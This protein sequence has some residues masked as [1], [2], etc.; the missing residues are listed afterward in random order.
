MPPSG[1]MRALTM[2]GFGG[3]ERLE[4]RE[5]P[6]PGPPGP[7]EVLVRIRAGALNRI[8]LFVLRG[9]PKARYAFPH[10]V[11]SDGAGLVEAVGEGVTDVHPG[12]RVMIN[13][14]LSCRRCPACLAGEQPYCREFRILG[15]HVE[16]TLAE[17]VR[18]PAA[19]V[20]RVPD[21]MDWPRAAAFPLATLTAWRMLVTRAR[22]RAGET[23][24][25]WGIGGGVSQAAL[26]IAGLAGARVIVTSSS[27]ARLEVARGLGADHLL[28]H[29]TADVA[30]EVRTLTGVG[31]D[32]V[33]DSVGQETWEASLRALRPGGRLV[34]CGATTGPMVSLDIRRLF[35]FQWEILGSTMGT[36]G[37]F[38][39]VVALAGRGRLLP[40]IDSVVPLAEG[41]TAFARMGDGAHIGKL[42][43]EV[44]A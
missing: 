16:G 12:D 18:V 11:G 33:V 38:R 43:I 35:W 22:L 13:P 2:T 39:E 26:Q 1:T 6:H 37:E 23:V 19:N 25:I 32:V 8:D 41:R 17:Y 20:A 7:G 24:L 27:P 44:S 14:G 28:N 29:T 4:V 36:Q 30:R 10:V 34:T 3:P 9:L 31:A 15:E 42:V 40:V 21:T 5:V